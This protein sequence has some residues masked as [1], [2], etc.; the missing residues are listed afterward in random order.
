MKKYDAVIIGAGPSGMTAALEIKRLAPRFD[1]LIIEKNS[2][3]GKKLRATGNGKCNITNTAAEGYE[4]SREFLVNL[5]IA[6][7]TYDNGLVYPYSESA[8]DVA[9]ILEERLVASGIEMIFDAEMSDIVQSDVGFV[10]TYSCK[11]KKKAAAADNVILSTGGKAGPG[12][13]TIGDGYRIARRFG[14][15]VVPAIPIL[16]SVSCESEDIEGLAG[17]RAKGVVRLLRDGITIFEEAGEV[18]FTKTGLSGICVFNMTRHMRFPKGEGL[19]SFRILVDFYPGQSAAEFIGD[20]N[21]PV[22][23]CLRSIVRDNVARLVLDRAEIKTRMTS[24]LKEDD[25]ARI[26]EVLHGMAFRPTGI[27]G[28]KD[29]QCTAGGVS[30]EE[31]DE[32]TNESRL[33]KGL[34]ITGELADYDG[35]CGGYN[36]TYAWTSGLRAGRAIAS[37]RNM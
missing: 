37:H 24:E 16:T 15:K 7:R 12:F 17:I 30:L 22:A 10:I 1:I 28:W 36:L 18:Q 29:A 32:V 19:D 23:T 2:S 35:P 9:T 33:I 27:S 26:D 13:G 14:H 34:Y 3:V 4:I 21:I 11:G 25:L 20:R 5:G 31:I 6:L 8:A